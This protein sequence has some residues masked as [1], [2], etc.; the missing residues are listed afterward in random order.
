FLVGA[1]LGG[2]AFGALGDRIGRVRAMTLSV[3]T[4]SVVSGLCAFVTAP[5]QLGLL[6]F[7]AALGM[8]GEWA[9]GVSLVMEVW[10]S[11]SRPLMAALIGAAGNTGFLLIGVAGL[12]LASFVGAVGD[13]LRLVLPEPW[14]ATLLRHDGWRLLF[15]VGAL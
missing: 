8:G 7:F 2:V 10:P 11:R 13:N 3:L 6:R 14:V 12:G 4:Y 5:W 1:A 9:L 15:L